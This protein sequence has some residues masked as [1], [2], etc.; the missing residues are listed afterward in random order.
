MDGT[1]RKMPNPF[2]KGPTLP[3]PTLSHGDSAIYQLNDNLVAIDNH[4]YALRKE[5]SY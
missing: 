3:Y 2:S 5:L 4:L 1:Y